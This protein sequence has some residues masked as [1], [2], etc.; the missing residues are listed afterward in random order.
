[1]AEVTN[2]SRAK[3]RLD[4]QVA[5]IGWLRGTGPNPIDYDEWD[6]RTGELLLATFGEDSTEVARYDEAVGKR[7][8]LPG[9]RGDANNMTLN[10]HGDWGILGRLERVESLLNEYATALGS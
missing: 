6:S 5:R 4:R 2:R 7:G 8:R 9:V 3:E 1:M 10:I